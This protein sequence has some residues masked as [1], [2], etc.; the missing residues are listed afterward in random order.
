MFLYHQSNLRGFY[1]CHQ[2][3]WTLEAIQWL[4]SGCGSVASSSPVINGVFKKLPTYC[5]LYW[6][7]ENNLARLKNA[8]KPN[9]TKLF[10]EQSVLCNAFYWQ[11]IGFC[12]ICLNLRMHAA[13]RL[14]EHTSLY[15]SMDVKKSF[16]HT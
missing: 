8:G 2:C 6:R 4:G 16:Q 15:L 3:S 12:L 14:K 7:D 5:Q 10:S 1:W 9:G 11:P 13:Q